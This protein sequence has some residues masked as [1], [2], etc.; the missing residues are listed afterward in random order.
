MSE[1]DGVKCFVCSR[2]I[3]LDS[4][5]FYVFIGR[6]CLGNASYCIDCYLKDIHD[7]NAMMGSYNQRFIPIYAKNFVRMNK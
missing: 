5:I 1:K 7:M 4:Q 3:E 6:T 2:H